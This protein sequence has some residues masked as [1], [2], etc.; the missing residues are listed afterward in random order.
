LLTLLPLIW[1]NSQNDGSLIFSPLYS[2]HVS[3]V[4]SRAIDFIQVWNHF[5]LIKF[6]IIAAVVVPVFDLGIIQTFFTP[7]FNWWIS[8]ALLVVVFLGYALM[9]RQHQTMGIYVG[10]FVGIFYLWTVYINDVQQRQLIPILPFLYFYLVQAIHW[11]VSRIIRNRTAAL[12]IT[13]GLLSVAIVILVGRNVH[14]WLDPVYERT[15]NL[16][17]GSVWLRENTPPGAIIMAENGLPA[18]LYSRRQA[19]FP[20]RVTDD[21]VGYLLDNKVDYVLLQP[22][23]SDWYNPEHKFDDYTTSVLLPV[24]DA[25]PELFNVVYRNDEHN[26][27]VYKVNRNE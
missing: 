9:L 18:Y 1:F 6:E 14:E 13:L 16:S 12:N 21:Q 20:D 23:L 11:L 4:S 27:T 19:I 10:L 8:I 2:S 5:P 15:V 25:H 26:T 7:L 24:L 22:D 3:Y 17:I